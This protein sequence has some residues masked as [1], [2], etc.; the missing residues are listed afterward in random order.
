MSPRIRT[1]SDDD[2]LAGLSR[3]LGQVGPARLTLGRLGKEVGLSPSTLVQRFG[4]K[5]KMLAR[6]GRGAG[7]AGPWLARFRAAG[8]GP[9]DALRETLLC[10]AALAQTPA[11]YRNHLAAFL[12]LDLADPVFRREAAKSARRNERHYRE[13]L[14]QAVAAA[15]LLVSDTRGLARTLLALVPGSLLHWATI[16]TG[17]ARAWLARDLDQVLDRFRPPVRDGRGSRGSRR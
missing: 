11:V 10:S 7:D 13:A 9:T 4:S 2:I 15:E 12:L 8:R 5:R 14:D 6:L 16:G 1:I 3:V 17:T